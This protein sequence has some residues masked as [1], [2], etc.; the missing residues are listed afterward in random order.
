ME[1]NI[2][3]GIFHRTH[4]MKVY[5]VVSLPSLP[6]TYVVVD[7]GSRCHQLSTTVIN[8]QRLSS[9]VIGSLSALSELGIV[10]M[11]IMIVIINS[12]YHIHPTAPYT[13]I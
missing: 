7:L 9:T 11:T 1:T 4:P 12:R 6:I 10:I 3:Y 2:E 13:L 5:A 8:Y